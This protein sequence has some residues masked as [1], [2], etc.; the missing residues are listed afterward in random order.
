MLGVKNALVEGWGNSGVD[1]R[2]S[3]FLRKLP[4]YTSSWPVSQ[5]ATFPWRKQAMEANKAFAR[6]YA[7]NR[8]PAV[9]S[10]MCLL[11]CTSPQRPYAEASALGRRGNTAK[12]LLHFQANLKAWS[13]QLQQRIKTELVWIPEGWSRQCAASC[14]SIIYILSRY[15]K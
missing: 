8:G 15:F 3:S 6:R 2:L 9:S 1:W 4:P 5:P 11:I 12:F 7:S 14:I 10:I 13:L